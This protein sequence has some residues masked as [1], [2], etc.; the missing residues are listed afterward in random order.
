M[1][2]HICIEPLTEFASMGAVREILSQEEIALV[3]VG[4]MACISSIKHLAEVLQATDRVFVQGL[5]A[6]EYGLGKN[7]EIAAKLIQLATASAQLKGI[8]VY[9]SCL[10]VLTNWDEQS[11]LAL[12]D[13]NLPIEFLY[14][15]PLVKR[16]QLPQRALQNIWRKWKIDVEPSKMPIKLAESRKIAVDF[17]EIIAK[18][19]EAVDIILLT[20]GGCASCLYDIPFSKRQRIYYTRFDDLFLLDCKAS[21]FVDAIESIFSKERDLLLLGTAV[22]KALGISLEEI[23]DMLGKDGYR[24]SFLQ[25]DGFKK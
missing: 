9:C 23:C 12:A 18:N 2:K 14:R 1:D 8:I 10:D 25:T 4:S 22:V 21:D 19:E 5:S 20:P 15:G 7:V 6:R 24:A 3:A 16:K 17:E 11:V 13:T